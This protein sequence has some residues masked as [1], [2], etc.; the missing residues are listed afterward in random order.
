MTTNIPGAPCSSSWPD[1]FLLAALRPW[2]ALAAVL[3][4]VAY[5]PT[6]VRLAITTSLQ[7]P[8]YRVW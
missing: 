7:S 6:L 5:G 1:L 4:L 3:I 2:L 8:G